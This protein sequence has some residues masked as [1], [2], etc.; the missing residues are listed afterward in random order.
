MD[1]AGK[2]STREKEQS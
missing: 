2:A 1:W